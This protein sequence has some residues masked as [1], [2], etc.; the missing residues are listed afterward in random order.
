MYT[1]V[2]RYAAVAAEMALHRT[3][4]RGFDGEMEGDLVGILS[5]QDLLAALEELRD[6]RPDQLLIELTVLAHGRRK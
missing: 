1:E 4:L 5:A 2:H 3:P 6:P